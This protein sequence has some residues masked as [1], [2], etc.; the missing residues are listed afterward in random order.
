MRAINIATPLI[1]PPTI[2][3]VW[4]KVDPVAGGAVA[5][6][7]VELVVPSAVVDGGELID[8]ELV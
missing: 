1:V 4:S 8:V 6:V 5:D 3:P 7:E 2:A